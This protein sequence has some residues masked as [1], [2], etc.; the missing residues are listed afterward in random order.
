MAFFGWGWIILTLAGVIAAGIAIYLYTAHKPV[1]PYYWII[2][3]AG[4]IVAI[5]GVLIGVYQYEEKIVW[6][7]QEHLRYEEEKP[8]YVRSYNYEHVYHYES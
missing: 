8:N 5:I 3:I 2:L 6:V 7:K 4:L 1:K